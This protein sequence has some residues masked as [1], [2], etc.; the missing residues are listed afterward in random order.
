MKM[1]KWYMDTELSC[2]KVDNP[3]ARTVGWLP[4][5]P[6]LNDVLV[7]LSS[8]QFGKAHSIA[9][10]LCPSHFPRTY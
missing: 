6:Q 5:F 3:R 8:N 10:F 7:A 9:Q 2:P 4:E 1:E